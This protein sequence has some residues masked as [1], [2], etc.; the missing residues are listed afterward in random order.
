M[1]KKT[2]KFK[3]LIKTDL[4][5]VSNQGKFA[6]R[7]SPGLRHRPEV[8]SPQG[9]PLVRS[10]AGSSERSERMSAAFRAQR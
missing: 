6:K 5:N 1:A 9:G 3:I 10:Q 4:E 7:I 2:K 8:R